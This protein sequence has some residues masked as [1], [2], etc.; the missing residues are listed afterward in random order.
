MTDPIAP[1][2]QTRPDH[3]AQLPDQLADK[4]IRL[5]NPLAA[6]DLYYNFYDATAAEVVVTTPETGEQSTYQLVANINDEES[7]FHAKVIMDPDTAHYILLLKGMDMPGRDEGAGANGFLQ[8][9]SDLKG[10]SLHTCISNQVMAAEGTFL[11]LLQD[12]NVKSLEVIGYSIGSIPA[13]YY[14]S[15]YGAQVTNIA[16]LGVPGTEID[17]YMSTQQ[18]TASLATSIGF[19]WCS[20]GFFPGA[21]GEFRDNLDNNVIGLSLRADAMGGTLGRV[22][23]AFGNQ[24][25]LDEDNLNL[26]GAAHVPEVYA[27]TAARQPDTPSVETTQTIQADNWKPLPSPGL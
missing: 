22:G 16:D 17:G 7:G 5:L 8:D 1:W 27:S 13:N 6:P 9:I 23:T 24:I 15:V 26:L 25:V 3:P 20:N 18:L 10:Q 2:S 21:H 11:D 4:N 12:P 19:N 14:A